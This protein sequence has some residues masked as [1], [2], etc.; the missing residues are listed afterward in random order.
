MTDIVYGGV[1]TPPAAVNATAQNKSE[2]K[3]L[4]RRFYDRLVESR[5]RMRARRW[6][7][8]LTWRRKARGSWPTSP[9]HTR[10]DR[11]TPSRLALQHERDPA[12]ERNAAREREA[13]RQIG[14]ERGARLGFQQ[15]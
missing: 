1:A 2:R 11:H 5:W 12:I 9:A 13:V 3:S 7:A 10:T 14:A 6:H 15:S 8:I 4:L